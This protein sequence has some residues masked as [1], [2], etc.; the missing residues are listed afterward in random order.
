MTTEVS[1]GNEVVREYCYNCGS[2]MFSKLGS[3]ANAREAAK[4]FFE[5]NDSQNV[6]HIGTSSEPLPAEGYITADLVIEHAQVQDDY[7]G[8]W[9]G[10]WPEE[11]KEQREQ[12]TERLQKVFGDWLDEHDLRPDFFMVRD[13]QKFNRADFPELI[14]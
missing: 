9:A 6:V 7:S 3:F 10:D 1:E 2:E 12:L 8:E 5:M 11:S 4:W 14:S 13:A